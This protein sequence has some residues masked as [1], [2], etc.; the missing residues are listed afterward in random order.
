MKIEQDEIAT[1]A[2]ETMSLGNR[3]LEAIDHN[4]AHAQHAS[5]WDEMNKW[6]RVRLRVQRIR[7]EQ[8]LSDALDARNVRRRV[9]SGLRSLGA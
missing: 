1:L 3:C 8:G 7:Q 5:R 4:I 9:R 6:H 2:R